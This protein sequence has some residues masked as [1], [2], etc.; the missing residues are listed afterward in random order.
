MV[1]KVWG[2]YPPSAQ[3][4]KENYKTLNSMTTSTLIEAIQSFYNSQVACMVMTI[5]DRD[6]II[7]FST[8][9]LP[10]KFCGIINCIRGSVEMTVGSSHYAMNPMSIAPITSCVSCTLHR[11]IDFKGKFVLFNY[12]CKNAMLRT[13]CFCDMILQSIKNPILKLSTEQFSFISHSIKCVETLN[14]DKEASLSIQLAIQHTMS[15]ILYILHDAIPERVSKSNM[16]QDRQSQIFQE[17]FNLVITNYKKEHRLIFYAE[18][19][20]ITPRYLSRVIKDLTGHSA[21]D[22]I[23]VLVTTEIMHQIHFTNRSIQQISYDL[24]FPNQ[25]FFGKYFKAQVG[26][27]PKVYRYRR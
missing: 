10:P 19:M 1:L 3:V 4:H 24:G 2:Y 20:C 12:A 27:S 14:T 21:S 5:Y 8:R 18:Q 25:S 15:S 16:I 22:W 17:F 6:F 7:P 11:S 9:G 13:D 26:C 23:D